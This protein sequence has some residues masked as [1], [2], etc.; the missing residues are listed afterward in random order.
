MLGLA[1]GWF[2]G[3]LTVLVVGP[4]AHEV[5]LDGAVRALAL[6]LPIPTTVDTDLPGRPETPVESAGYFAI[7]EA[8]ANVARHSHARGAWISMR[9]SGGVL[10]MMVGDDGIGGADPDSGLKIS[11]YWLSTF[12][13]AP[14]SGS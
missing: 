5:P 14:T 11:F 8:L 13:P 12:S 2:V 3:A 6:S 7:A 1:V 4:P 10:F 9:H